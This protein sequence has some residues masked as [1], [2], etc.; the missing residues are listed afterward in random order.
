LLEVCRISSGES[1]ESL[2]RFLYEQLFAP[3]AGAETGSLCF[4]I[5]YLVLW[6][7]PAAELHRRRLFLKI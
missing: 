5:A 2:R 7:I 3:W 1:C 6:M 4:A